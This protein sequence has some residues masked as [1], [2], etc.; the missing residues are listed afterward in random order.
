M[1]SEKTTAHYTTCC[2]IW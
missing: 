2:W 1:T